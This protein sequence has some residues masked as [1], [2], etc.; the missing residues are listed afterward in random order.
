MGPPG[1]GTEAALCNPSAEGACSSA[2]LT[3]VPGSS[4]A[5][6]RASPGTGSAAGSYLP[7]VRAASRKLLPIRSRRATPMARFSSLSPDR[8]QESARIWKV[9][10]GPAKLPSN[11]PRPED[12]GA[13]DHLQ[14]R[15]LPSVTLLATSGS[16][17]DVSDIPTTWTV[18]YVYPRTGVPG[19]EM[20][21]GWNAIPGAVGCTPQSC[22]YRDD[23]HEFLALD[24]SVVGLSTQ[25]TDAQREFAEREHI[26]FP[27]LSDEDREFGSALELPTFNVQGEER[28]KRVTLIAR[29]GQIEHVRYPVFPPNE[30]AVETLG[31]LRSHS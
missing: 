15:L 19:V 10:H 20:P 9:I 23:Y 21:S 11:L 26:P 7:R 31:W 3:P 8:A 30:D 6:S 5:P 25:A 17:I 12:D 28:Y 4:P 18:V 22:S 24:A 16:R 13:C 27:L 14:G 2:P 1:V 29:G